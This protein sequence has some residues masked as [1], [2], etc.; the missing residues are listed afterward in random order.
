MD[1]S[2]S[3]TIVLTL[4]NRKKFTL[5]WLNWAKSQNCDFKIL[6]A[7]GS[8]DD[9]VLKILNEGE[10]ENLKIEYHRYPNDKS[11][12]DW[13]SK[14]E[15]IVSKVKTDF[16]I[17]ADNDDFILFDNLKS[18]IKKF[19]SCTDVNV[20]SRP[21]LRIKFDY[22]G[23]VLNNHLYPTKNIFLR[24]IKYKEGLKTLTND[25]PKERLKYVINNFESS[26]IWY[27]IHRT[28]NF[29][30]IHKKILF[31]NYKIVMMQEW[32]LYYSSILS[33]KCLIE[34]E[35]PYLVRQSMT[36][37]GASSLVSSE[38]LDKIFLN[39]SWSKDLTVLISDLYKDLGVGETKKGFKI[40][41]QW[42][43]LHF[44]KYLLAWN[45]NQYFA[46]RFREHKYY[47]IIKKIINYLGNIINKNN[48]YKKINNYHNVNGIK[49]L[50]NFLKQN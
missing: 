8:K 7:D 41:E 50:F 42:F 16:C 17:L 47:L 5:R 13:F 37:E 18:A 46:D 31:N 23:G 49:S 34:D 43:K 3:L 35:T 20:Y 40:F 48:G 22:K 1:L 26:L 33:G 15:S 21:Q 45:K 24:K 4:R 29:K 10:F 28:D 38:R 6:I 27:G 25:D 2:K 30:K 12:E 39:N 14:L 11:I 36:S 32:Y 19:T 44:H 9:Y